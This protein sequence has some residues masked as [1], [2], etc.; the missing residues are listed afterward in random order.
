MAGGFVVGEKTE[1]LVKLDLEFHSIDA[2]KQMVIGW[3]TGAPS[4]N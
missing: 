3:K 1:S 4:R 2:L